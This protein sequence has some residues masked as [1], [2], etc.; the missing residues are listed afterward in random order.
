MD[1]FDDEL[2]DISEERTITEAPQTVKTLAIL[3]IVG[4]SLWC[5]MMLIAMLWMMMM[6]NSFG[7]GFGGRIIGEMMGAFLVGF[8]I[9][10][11]FHV[12]GLIAA[13][14]MLKG[15][16]GAFIMYAIVT[17]LWS[18]LLLLSSFNQPQASNTILILVMALTSIGF[19]IGFGVNMKDM[20][21]N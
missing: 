18:L 12:L 5:L 7:G 3:S 8:L 17:G 2:V 1:E 15:K 20:P 10:I 6:A 13:V 9:M 11:V 19:I 16:K 4:N 14:R 21:K